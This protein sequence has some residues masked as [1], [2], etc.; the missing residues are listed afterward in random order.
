MPTRG[1]ECSSDQMPYIDRKFPTYTEFA[2]ASLED[3]LGK[4]GIDEALK[5][6][7]NGFES[8]VLMNNGNGSFTSNT[9]PKAAQ[10][11][12][13][14]GIIPEYVDQDENIDLIIAGNKFGSEVETPRYDASD[15][16]VLKGDG[17]GKFIPLTIE[18]SG[19]YLP[20]NVKSIA[21]LKSPNGDLILA[22]NNN[23]VLQVFKL[24]QQERMS[25]N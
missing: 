3:I 7:V 4:K 9:L 24:K 18:D 5:L 13:I 16:L 12:P 15:G 25:M 1:K 20:K 21:K 11:A 22:G 2:N 14:M 17:T 19:L 23:D 8:I 6:E 10:V